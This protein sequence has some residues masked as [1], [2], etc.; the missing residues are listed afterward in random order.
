MGHPYKNNNSNN[1]NMNA[2]KN[3]IIKMVGKN[4]EY[5]EDVLSQFVKVKINKNAFLFTEGEV[6]SSIYF[7]ESGLIQVLQ[8][9]K[10]GNEKTTDIIVKDNWFTDLGSFKNKIPSQLSAK[11]KNDSIVY[12]ISRE[13]FQILMDDVP[14]FA[15]AYIT[16]IEGKYKESMERIAAFNTLNS[17]EKIEWLNKFKPDFLLYVADKLIASYLGISKETYCRQKQN[18]RIIAKCQ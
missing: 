2:L 16:I 5:L 8:V 12:K 17:Y 13:S 9:D 1:N 4:P 11:A 18:A 10:N 6:C 15:Q 14:K 7:I 3:D